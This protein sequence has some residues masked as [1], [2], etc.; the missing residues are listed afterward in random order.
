MAQTVCIHKEC[1][2]VKH[3]TK[4]NKKNTAAHILRNIEIT[5]EIQYV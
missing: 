1:E 3:D 2:L 5:T 4:R